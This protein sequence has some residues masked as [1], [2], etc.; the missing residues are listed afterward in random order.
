MY[1]VLADLDRVP[2]IFKHGRN[3]SLNYFGENLSDSKLSSPATFDHTS[4]VF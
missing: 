2:S 1:Y 3:R 4:M